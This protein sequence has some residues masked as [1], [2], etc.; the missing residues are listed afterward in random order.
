M[1]PIPQLLNKI[2]TYFKIFQSRYAMNLYILLLSLQ[3]RENKIVL[4]TMFVWSVQSVGLVGQ[5]HTKKQLIARIIYI[6]P[7]LMFMAFWNWH[8]AQRNMENWLDGTNSDCLKK[9]QNQQW[10]QIKFLFYILLLTVYEQRLWDELPGREHLYQDFF[11][12]VG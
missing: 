9:V 7:V 8:S 10:K 5:F 12:A 3:E 2:D 11:W 4:V 6:Q 1:V